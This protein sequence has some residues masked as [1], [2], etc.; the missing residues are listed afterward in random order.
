MEARLGTTGNNKK[1]LSIY[2]MGKK[3]KPKQVLKIAGA[4]EV[5]VPKSD[6]LNIWDP[7]FGWVLKDGKPTVNTKPY[8][9]R[10][11]RKPKQ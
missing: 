9:E 2:N 10:M 11:R 6:R 4:G 7:D 8:W 1:R 3:D 5:D